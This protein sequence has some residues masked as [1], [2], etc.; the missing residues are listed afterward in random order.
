MKMM[1]SGHAFGRSSNGLRSRF[2]SRPLDGDRPVI[3]SVDDKRQGDSRLLCPLND[4]VPALH[5]AG[6]VPDFR[7]D[8]VVE[9]GQHHIITRAT[10][11]TDRQ[12][13]R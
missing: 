13:G 9:D 2:M 8:V 4:P 5:R 11:M 3:K 1:A 6:R 10:T 12:S 7:R